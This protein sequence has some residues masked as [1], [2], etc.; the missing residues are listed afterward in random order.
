MNYTEYRCLSACSSGC[1]FFTLYTALSEPSRRSTARMVIRN[2][3]ERQCYSSSSSSSNSSCSC[4]LSLGGSASTEPQMQRFPTVVVL[5]LAPLFILL[6]DR[7]FMGSQ[8]GRQPEALCTS[9]TPCQP[10]A[11]ARRCLAHHLQCF[12][13]PPCLASALLYFHRLYRHFRRK[14]T[15]SNY[16]AQY[17]TETA[18]YRRG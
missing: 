9:G 14:S 2:D 11:S 3:S 16:D 18:V 8:I 13:Q 12:K 5:V 7:F 10:M 4:A 1:Q 15:R 6:P 17:A